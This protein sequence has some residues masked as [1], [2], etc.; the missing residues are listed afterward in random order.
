MHVDNRISSCNM[1][2][3]GMPPGFEDWNWTAFRIVHL[4]HAEL[5]PLQVTWCL[6]KGTELLF[7]THDMELTHADSYPSRSN[8]LV[9]GCIRIARAL[10]LLST[11]TMGWVD[12]GFSWRPST[13]KTCFS[14][15][16]LTLRDGCKQSTPL[17]FEYKSTLSNIPQAR[18]MRGYLKISTLANQRK[19]HWGSLTGDS[20]RDIP[21]I[22]CAG[23]FLSA[24]REIP[25]LLVSEF[26]M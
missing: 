9:S 10:A 1:E 22:I 3:D 11:T 26:E 12:L 7:P 8:I 15:C 23:C 16:P 4:E 13:I 5:S 17:D 14:P 20:P 2:W 18:G 25:R 24:S 6:F 19:I 21:S